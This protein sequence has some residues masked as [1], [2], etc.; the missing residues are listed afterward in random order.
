LVRGNR[1]VQVARREREAAIDLVIQSRLG[2]EA[3]PE[4]FSKLVLRSIDRAAERGLS[5]QPEI[6]AECERTEI[7]QARLEVLLRIRHVG[8]ELRNFSGE[9]GLRADTGRSHRR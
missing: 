3:Q 8:F 9:I 6:A 1:I 2:I 7:F 5:P 4:A